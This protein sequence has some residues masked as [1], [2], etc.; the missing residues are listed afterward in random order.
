MDKVIA[1]ISAF[2]FMLILLGSLGFFAYNI[3]NNTPYPDEEPSTESF[4]SIIDDPITDPQDLTQLT[5]QHMQEDVTK[6]PG[7][8]L[9]P[10]PKTK[11]Q[12]LLPSLRQ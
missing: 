1:T 2:I 6:L 7:G 11:F 9:L 5:L 10:P 4:T 8:Y 12:C 3:F